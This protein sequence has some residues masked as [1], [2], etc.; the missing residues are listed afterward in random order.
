MSVSN[1][2]GA[3]RSTG[4]RAAQSI[5]VPNAVS[6][7]LGRLSGP[8]LPEQPGLGRR[9]RKR[10]RVGSFQR[11]QGTCQW[12]DWQNFTRLPPGPSRKTRSPH[13]PIRGSRPV[14]KPHPFR[15][16]VFAGFKTQSSHLPW[17]LAESLECGFKRRF[18]RRLWEL[19][20]DALPERP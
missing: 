20:P 3:A 5:A 16:R 12:S 1:G 11:R 4:A 17:P 7:D 10:L 13:R 18:L 15:S 6:L 8:A 14:H 9:T 19:I 2:S